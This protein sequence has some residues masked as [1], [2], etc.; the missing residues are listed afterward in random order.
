VKPTASVPE[1]RQSLGGPLPEVGLPPERVIDELVVAVEQGLLASDGARFFGWVIGGAL[2]AAVAADW[3]TA[4]WDQNAAIVA[5]SHAA[6]V[7]E[8]V[9]GAWMKD[10]L[11]LP[12]GAS[13]ALVTGAL[14]TG[15]QMAHLTCLAAAR[16]WLLAQRGWDVERRG[17]ANAPAVCVLASEL[18]HASVERALRL[19]GIGTDAIRS[20]QADATGAIRVDALGKALDAAAGAPTI[21]CLQAGELSSGAF[22]AFAEACALGRARGAW[23]HVDGAFGLWAS[24]SPALRSFT[25]R[26]DQADSWVTDGHKWLNTP[27]DLGFAFVAHPQAHRAAM[28]ASRATYFAY[29]EV[30]RD[31]MDWNPEWCASSPATGTT[32][33]APTR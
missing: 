18:R 5:T 27:F 15:S 31:Q 21:V 16:N 7:V 11:G 33:D 9:C 23:T 17:L 26:M 10:V 6:A 25:A 20:I 8:E 30:G 32:I 12:A 3:L 13:F 1:L 2:P 28:T 19:L 24:A 14:V 4:A 29:D 22:D